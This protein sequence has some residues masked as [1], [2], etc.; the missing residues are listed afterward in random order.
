[1]G[2]FGDTMFVLFAAES[3]GLERGQCTP[4]GATG[5]VGVSIGKGNGDI[6]EKAGINFTQNK[7]NEELCPGQE[8][9]NGHQCPG[10]T[11]FMHRKTN[12]PNTSKP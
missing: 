11:G 2:E 5:L 12:T 7:R 6:F 8:S 3:R 10:L 9:D 1:L 4:Y